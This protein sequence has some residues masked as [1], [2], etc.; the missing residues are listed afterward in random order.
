MTPCIEGVIMVK[1]KTAK[2]QVRAHSLKKNVSA[3]VKSKSVRKVKKPS[4]E[5]IRLV[6]S[7]TE[8]EKVYIKMLAAK[9][10]KTISDYL[11]STPRSMM[12]KDKFSYSKNRYKPNKLTEKVLRESENGKYL[13]HHESIEDF[14][15]SMGIDLNA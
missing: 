2:A 14:W 3:P 5:K 12:P 7:C 9:E 15:K 8:D 13:E 10:R 11:L 6:I 4:S 1:K